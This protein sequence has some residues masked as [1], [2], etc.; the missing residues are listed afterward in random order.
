M[1]EEGAEVAMARLGGDPVDRDAVDGGR[2]G[3]ARAQ[4]VA[5]DRDVVEAGGVG[6]CVHKPADRT[7]SDALGRSEARSVDPGEERAGTR[8]ADRE[9]GVECLDG[10]GLPAFA[11]GDSDQLSMA[12]LSVLERRTVTRMPLGLV[13]MSARSRAESSPGRRAEA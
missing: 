5:S 8:R 13:M 6:A 1:V 3:V 12:V 2:G 11:A 7:G 4:R 10:I 9:P